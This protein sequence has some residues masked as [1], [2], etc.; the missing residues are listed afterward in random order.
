[1]RRNLDNKKKLTPIQ[2]MDNVGLYSKNIMN[3]VGIHNDIF[4]LKTMIISRNNIG[5]NDVSCKH[6]K[7]NNNSCT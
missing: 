7:M 2:I 5:I 6:L 1:M 4:L 3:R